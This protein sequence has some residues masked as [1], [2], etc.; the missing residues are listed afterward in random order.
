MSDPLFTY[1]RIDPPSLYLPSELYCKIGSKRLSMSMLL[2]LLPLIQAQLSCK[3]LASG[4]TQTVTLY[5]NFINQVGRQLNR[6]IS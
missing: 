5:Q 2:H 4:L 1:V 6:S 3:S